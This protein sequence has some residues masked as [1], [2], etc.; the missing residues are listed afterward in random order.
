MFIY[1]YL[2]YFL[3][4]KFCNSQVSSFFLGKKLQK[5]AKFKNFK[6]FIIYYFNYKY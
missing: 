1:Y 6:L 3:F 2:F 4:I 5:D